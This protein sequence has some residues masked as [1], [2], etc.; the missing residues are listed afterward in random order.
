M[1]QD[2]IL[3]SQENKHEVQVTNDGATILKAIHLDNPAAKVLVNVSKTQDAEVGDGTTS[4]CVL[5]GEIIREA[6]RLV[7]RKVHPQT[8]IEGLRRGAQ[9]ALEALQKSSIN[10]SHDPVLMREDLLNIA[11]TTLSR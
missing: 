4:V 10:R 11:R 3:Q 1:L 9:V 6:E 2:K 5:A 7:N 8:I